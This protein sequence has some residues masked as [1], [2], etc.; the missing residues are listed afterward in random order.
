MYD[1]ELLQK[2]EK[3][4]VLHFCEDEDVDN[5]TEITRCLN[6]LKELMPI[7]HPLSVEFRVMCQDRVSLIN[8]LVIKP[9]NPFWQL[10]ESSIPLGI[11]AYGVLYFGISQISKVPNINTEILLNWMEK[12]LD[13]ESP[14]P[15]KYNIHWGEINIWA[16]RARIID[17]TPFQKRNSFRLHTSIG[18]FEY[19]LERRKDGLWVYGPRE[20]V[21]TSR[22]PFAIQIATMCGAHKIRISVYWTQWYDA[23]SPGYNALKKAIAKIID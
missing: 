8:D 18:D 13:Q 14:D 19:P 12:A 4:I 21:F 3:Q 15:E 20:K 17:E 22:P 1:C 10:Q 7:T 2:G 6:A 5:I 11:D 16:V 9:P 23:N